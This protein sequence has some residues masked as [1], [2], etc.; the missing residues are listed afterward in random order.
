MK[1]VSLWDN[2]VAIKYPK[3]PRLVEGARR[4]SVSVKG[5]IDIT[6]HTETSGLR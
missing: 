5:Q 1:L 2:N 4:S 3:I 6:G